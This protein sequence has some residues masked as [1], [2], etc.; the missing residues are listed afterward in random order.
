MEL[1]ARLANGAAVY[2]DY[3]HTPD[4]LERLLDGAAAAHRRTAARRVRRRRRPRPR[5]A[6]ADGRRR[7]P[8]RR[9]DIV[10]DDNPRGEDPATIRAAV[11]RRLPRRPRDRRPRRGHRGGAERPRRRRRAGGR[12]QGPRAG[13]DDRRRGSSRSTTSTRFAGWLAPHDR[14][15]DSARH[16]G[17]HRRLPAHARSHATGVSI[18]TRTLRPGDLFVALVGENGDGHDHRRRRPRPRRRRRAGPSLPDGLPD[19]APLLQ[20]GDTLAGLRG[21]GAFAR[22]RFTGRLVGGDRQRRQ[23]HDQGNAARHPGRRRARPTRPRPRYNNHWGVPLTLARLPA[24]AAFAVVEIGMNHA[25]EILPLA[26][27]AR[28]HVAADHQRRAGAYRPS[29]QHRGDRR[30]EGRDH[31]RAGAGRHRGA[32]GRFRACCRACC[33]HASDVRLFGTSADGRRATARCRER[34]R[35]A[36]IVDRCLDRRAELRHPAGMRPG[37]TWRS[38]PSPRWRPP[39]ALGARPAPVAPPPLPSFAPMAGRG[40]RRRIALPGGTAL[41]LDESYNAYAVVGARRAGGA[42]PCSRRRAA[43]RCWATCWNWARTGRASMPRWPPTSPPAADLLFACGPLMRVAVRRRCPPHSAAPMPPTRRRSHR[44]S[45]PRCAPGDAI[46]VKGSLGSRMKTHR[47]GAGSSHRR[48]RADAVSI[49]PARS[50]TSSSCSTCSA[51]SRSAS[52][53]ACL[54][55]LVISLLLGPTVIRWLKSVQRSGQPIR[56]D[57]PERHLIEKKGTPTMGGVLILSAL[58]RLDVAVG[59]SAQRLCLG[60]AVRHAGLRRARLRRRLHQAVQGATSRACRAA[61]S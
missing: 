29:R 37:A 35:M 3:A 32:A 9:P 38:T 5:Q 31:R 20:V 21:L 58:T 22:A 27:L 54:T 12:R 17:G 24:D 26:R 10:T 8:A 36:A 42:A 16:A 40:A 49:S 52:G 48:R 11:L 30:R 2:V 44:S 6:A 50:P 18:D 7:R 34:T 55:A 23:D 14:A 43:S 56:P 39:T 51:T 28:P 46:L 19:D 4:A 41:L 53:A 25:G 15:L 33:A 45:R 47:A 60:G 59:R 61:A 1:A 57:G 13:P